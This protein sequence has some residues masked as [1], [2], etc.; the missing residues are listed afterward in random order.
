MT[1]AAAA[2][3]GTELPND[4]DPFYN[5]ET[6]HDWNSLYVPL[7]NFNAAADTVVDTMANS[8]AEHSI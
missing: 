8:I 7:I 3:K 5:I 1:T 4:W 2:I 6:Q